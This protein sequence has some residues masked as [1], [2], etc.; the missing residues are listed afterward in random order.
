VPRE[1]DYLKEEPEYV[2]PRNSWIYA[3]II[4]GI[5]GIIAAALFLLIVYLNAPLFNEGN[6][7]GDNMSDATAF[8][9]VGWQCLSAFI[10]VLLLPLGVGIAIGT[11]SLNRKQSLC[12][13]ALVELI[14]ALGTILGGNTAVVALILLLFFAPIAGLMSLV[15]RAGGLRLRELLGK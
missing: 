14:A 10:N 11:I 1:D 2:L 4:G 8:S 9:M 15:G 6:R 12:A 7:L 5:G 3:M 13:G